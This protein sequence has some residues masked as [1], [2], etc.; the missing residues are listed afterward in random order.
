MRDFEI[1]VI[2]GGLVGTAC[3]ASL[4]SSGRT[5]LVIER[6]AH[7]GQET[8]SRNS[9][10]VHAGLYYPPSS[11]KAKLCLRGRQL[12]EEGAARGELELQRPGKFVVATEEG[13]LPAL[14]ALQRNATAS[15]VAVEIIEGPH[16]QDLEPNLRVRAALWSPATAI[17]DAHQLLQAFRRRAASAGAT[18]AVG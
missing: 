18:F 5:V 9:G 17:V 7:L 13:E 10:V 8:S 2:G 1:V 4:A 14:E 11:L 3:A 12:I 6:H 15:G 16:L